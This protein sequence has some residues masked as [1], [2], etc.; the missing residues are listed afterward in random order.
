VPSL[1]FAVS[2][3]AHRRPIAARAAA[4]A[5]LLLLLSLLVAACSGGKAKE[6]VS[7]QAVD[8]SQPGGGAV[9]NAPSS[10]SS[11]L[12]TRD[13]SLYLRDMKT[14]K[15]IKLCTAPEGLFVTYPAWSPDGRQYVYALDSPFIGNVAAN[16][17]SDF[18]LA[19]ANG[20]NRRLLLKHDQSGAELESPSWTPDGKTIV[21]S[22]FLTQYDAQGQYQGQVYEAR[23]IDVASAAVTKLISDA[24]STALCRD[25]SKLTYV[26]FNQTDFTSYGIWVADANGQNGKAIVNGNTGMQAF[27]A[28]RFSPDCKQIIFAAIGGG[29]RKI[30]P[31]PKGGGNLL[32]RLLGPLLPA[33]A[34]AHGAPWD[35]WLVNVDGSG[36]KRVTS[37]NEDLP[38]L[39]WAADGQSVL[40]VGTNGLYE[41]SP[42]GSNI[43]KIGQGAVHGQIS[44][45]QKAA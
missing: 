12:I 44:W 21:Y 11:V 32:T 17:G 15:E 23:S 27:F 34:A 41:M 14:N 7:A 36:L 8:C 9:T 1:P 22:Y 16:W 6:N 38:F 10:G 4:S 30:D 24:N 20:G 29:I 2:P 33:A 31:A 39:E 19:D 25:G 18:Y 37:L 5:V 35:L 42:D 43:K 45:R 13:D 28:P 40:F 3:R 26:N